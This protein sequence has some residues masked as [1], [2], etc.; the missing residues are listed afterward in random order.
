VD[1]V[2]RPVDR[3]ALGNKWVWVAIILLVNLLGAILYLAVGRK[4]APVAEV[5]EPTRLAPR[6]GS[7]ADS[8]Y[9]PRSAAPERPA[10]PGAD[11]HRPGGEVAH[12]GP[13]DI[14]PR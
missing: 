4:P 9:G 13:D 3:V 11:E 12:P 2:R 14:D 10:G 8:L 7:I 6:A 1:L 5:P